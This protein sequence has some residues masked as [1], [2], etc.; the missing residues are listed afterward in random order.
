MGNIDVS[1][2][3]VHHDHAYAPFAISWQT[4]HC[5]QEDN[6]RKTLGG[7][8]FDVTLRVKVLAASDTVFIF[9]PEQW[10]GTTEAAAALNCNNVVFT[11]SANHQ[12]VFN[13]MKELE[14]NGEVEANR[15]I[16]LTACNSSI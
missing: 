3:P 15:L 5:I 14:E 2:S 12:I 10:H 13:R 11:F 6:Q 16:D 7:N 9:D 1:C 4:Q 8:F